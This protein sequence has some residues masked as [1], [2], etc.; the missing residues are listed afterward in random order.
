MGKFWSLAGGCCE[1]RIGG[2]W[3]WYCEL[4]VVVVVDWFGFVDCGGFVVGVGQLVCLF[5]V[6]LWLVWFVD[7]FGLG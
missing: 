6:F 4:Q 3:L 5:L 2:W 7:D 1:K